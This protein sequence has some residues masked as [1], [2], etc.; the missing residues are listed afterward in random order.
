MDSITIELMVLDVVESM[1][2]GQVFLQLNF[3]ST[4][5]ELVVKKLFR[6]F[7]LNLYAI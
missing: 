4:E 7:E 5:L 2:F 3:E 6:E 1:E